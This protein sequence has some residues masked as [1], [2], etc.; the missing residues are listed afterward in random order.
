M[1]RIGI[2]YTQGVGIDIDF[3]AQFV[4]QPQVFHIQIR[5][6]DMQLFLQRQKRF[7]GLQK[8]AQDVGQVQNGV[9]G[10][11][12]LARNDAVKRVQRVKQEVRMNLRLQGAQLGLRDQAA[13]FGFAKLFDLFDD[14]GCGA[15]Q[16]HAGLR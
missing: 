3:D 1:E 11:L 13:H 2:G 10:A 4:S 16:R 6:D 7:A 9:A 5:L 14:Q 15:A 12:S 8:V